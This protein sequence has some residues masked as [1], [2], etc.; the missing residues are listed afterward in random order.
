MLSN[1]FIITYNL[2]GGHVKVM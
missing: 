2:I 1:M